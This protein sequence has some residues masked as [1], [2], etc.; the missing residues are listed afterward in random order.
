MEVFRLC[1]DCQNALVPVESGIGGEY[2]CSKCRR[3]SEEKKKKDKSK[4]SAS[5]CDDEE[6]SKVM[7]KTRP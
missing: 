6:E 2:V 1:S 7:P 5:S 3:A 4:P